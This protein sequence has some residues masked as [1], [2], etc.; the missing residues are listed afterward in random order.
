MGK[1]YQLIYINLMLM[2]GMNPSRKNPII[3]TDATQIN[4]LELLKSNPNLTKG[5]KNK[6]G[7]LQIDID[8]CCSI[9]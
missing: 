1:D 3:R 2:N 9:F 4:Y 8:P 5:N 6:V 7:Y